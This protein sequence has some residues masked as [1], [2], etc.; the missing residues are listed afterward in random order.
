V[1]NDVYYHSVTLLCNQTVYLNDKKVDSS[2]LIT[3]PGEYELQMNETRILFSLRE[4]KSPVIEILPQT[5][6][7]TVRTSSNNWWMI[8]ASWVG[9]FWLKKLQE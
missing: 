7:L 2:L 4:A 1:E 3:K 9:L 6:R 8:P 5:P